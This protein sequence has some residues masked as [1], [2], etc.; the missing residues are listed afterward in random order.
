MTAPIHIIC[1][2]S[3]DG[4]PRWNW[5]S[6]QLPQD[7]PLSQVYIDEYVP[8]TWLKSTLEDDPRLV[9]TDY[10]DIT[11]D[12][13]WLYELN[14]EYQSS[15]FDSNSTI[16]DKFL[17]NS[18]LMY[19][20]HNG[21][22]YLIVNITMEAWCEDWIIRHI[23]NFF[24]SKNIPLDRVIYATGA[25]NAAS[26]FEAKKFNMYPLPALPMELSSSRNS[27]Q[28][29]INCLDATHVVKR[30]LCFNRA[31]RPHRVVLLAELSSC[32]LLDQFY[33][34]FPNYNNGENLIDWVHNKF[35]NMPNGYEY[36][37]IIKGIPMPMVLDT[38]NWGPNLALHHNTD[39][40]YKFYKSSGISVVTET[41]FY[42]EVTFFSEKTFH[43]IRYSQP[44]IMVNTFRSLA[45]LKL[46]GYKTF[47]DW[48]DE[49]YDEIRNPQERLAAI[50]S[51]IEDIAKW[52]DQKFSNFLT[53]S[54]HICEHN[55][56]V[57][58]AS[59]NR[60]YTSHHWD[61]LFKS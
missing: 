46:L 2:K 24:I 20:L 19:G 41:I 3:I 31:F 42:D 39:N 56:T 37:E 50:V 48:I 16:L 22:G 45:A 52:D 11:P 8:K 36:M 9:Y 17:D 13:Q 49:S 29:S 47:S 15:N 5:S 60:S 14:W 4:I 44:F 33:Y 12:D 55:L 23:E 28:D 40:V 18:I 51:L 34:S 32:N 58:Q 1:N 53:E 35:H 38:N 30:F 25:L 61:T 54:K 10:N 26:I 27:L 43:P 6:N 21:S 59:L 57:L 7:V